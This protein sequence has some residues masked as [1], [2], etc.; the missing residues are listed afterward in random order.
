[1]KITIKLISAIVLCLV[2]SGCA[3]PGRF[4]IKDNLSGWSCYLENPDAKQQDTWTIEDGVL[5]CSGTE[6]G[7][8]YSNDSYSDFTLMLQWRWPDEKSAGKGGVL[9]DTTGEHKIWPRSLEA[10]INAN[11]AGDFWALDGYELTGTPERTKSLSHE[12]YGELINIR[13]MQASENAAGQW[14]SYKIVAEG[15]SVTLMINDKVVNKG[16]RTNTSGGKIC[17]T[18]EGT[19]IEFRNIKILPN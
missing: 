11:D 7:Y 14:N 17:I 6:L 18:S 16:T 4:P 13:K 12:K 8:M 19:A 15:T 3:N 5:I 9:I 2:I 10:Q 1:M